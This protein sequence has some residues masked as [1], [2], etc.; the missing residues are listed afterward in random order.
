[1]TRMETVYQTYADRSD[2]NHDVRDLLPPH[3]KVIGFAGTS[4]E[5]QYSFWLPLGGRRVIDF[6]PTADRR[7]PDPTGLEAIVTSEWG[8]MDRFGKTPQQLADHLGWQ[9][10]GTT[11]VR[12]LASAEPVQWSVLAPGAH[13]AG[14][15]Q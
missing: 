9:I 2:A 7:P 1:M 6:T 14:N 5:S 13:S 4:G 8:C 12:S 15:R 10:L 3:A 11:P